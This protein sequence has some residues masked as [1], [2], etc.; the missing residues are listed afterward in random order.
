MNW[1]STLL[2]PVV[3]ATFLGV[4]ALDACGGGGDSGSGAGDDGGTTGGEGGVPPGT[5]LP[6]DDGGGLGNG[7]LGGNCSEVLTEHGDN[8]RSGLYGAEAKLKPANVTKATFGK[9]FELTVDGKVDAQPLYVQ[10]VAISGKGTHDVLYVVTE[11][12]SAYAFDADAAPG[13]GGPLWKMSAVPGGETPSDDRGC[14]Q[15]TPEI[16]ITATPV[17]DRATSTMYFVAMSKNGGTYH[18]RLH[19]VDI[20]SGAEKLG[21]P[22]EIVATYPG[23]TNKEGNGT[24]V[25]FAP[26]QH[27]DRSALLLDHGR[28]YTSWASHC[29][30]DPYTGWII[31]HDATT[32]ANVAVWNT[33]PNGS[34]ASFWNAGA[35]PA[36]DAVGYVYHAS[37]NGDFDTNLTAAGF[38]KEA[39]YGNS[40]V[41]LALIGGAFSV[42]DYF[43]MANE[44]TESANDIDLG[45]G[46]LLLLPDPVGSA[47]HPHLLVGGGKD[48]HLYLLDRDN[49]GKFDSAGANANAVQDVPLATATT[50]TGDTGEFGAGA[51][52][53][54]AVYFG[55][56]GEPLKRWAIANAK[57]TTP[58]ASKTSLAFTYPGT[59]PTVSWDGKDPATAI[60]WAHENTSPPVLHAYSAGD[61]ATEYWNSSQ[62]SGN[63]DMPAGGNNKFI[64]PLV[65][66]GRVYFGTASSV[67]VYGN[68]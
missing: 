28:V 21:G 59:T 40:F 4:C 36:A 67:V 3:T 24:T 7:C 50:E 64:I 65:A 54:G 38:P 68:L 16:G 12:G 18:Q 39:N 49:L 35:G 43:A 55:G 60:V 29:D 52:F 5:P 33:V 31:A 56:V 32:L 27:K 26:G 30:N 44:V 22:K 10:N 45:S 6:G 20:T 34:E 8:A 23:S 37:G 57:I 9:L 48:G 13:A 11:H 42:T 58:E 2:L 62:A 61:L 17:I 19:A 41:K 1:K 25:T 47:A 14:N 53:N 66:N 63:R 15:V 46:G 51:Y